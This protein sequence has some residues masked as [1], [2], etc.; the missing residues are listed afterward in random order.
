MKNVEGLTEV[1]DFKKKY[2]TPKSTRKL[3]SVNCL[4]ALIY[5]LNAG[6]LDV[7]SAYID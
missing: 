7:F 3:V 1:L 5:L 6:R 2:D 4:K